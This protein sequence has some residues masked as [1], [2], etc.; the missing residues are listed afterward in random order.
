MIKKIIFIFK[1]N[2]DLFKYMVKNK[3][4]PFEWTVINQNGIQSRTI[5]MK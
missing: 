2:K 1:F 3:Q 5:N 4:T